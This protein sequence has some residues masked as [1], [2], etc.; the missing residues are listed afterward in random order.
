M[1][2][3]IIQQPD[4]K[5]AMFSSFSDTF[6]YIDGSEDQILEAIGEEAKRDAIERSREIIEQLKAGKKP[7]YQFT[8]SWKEAVGMHQEHRE[9]VRDKEFARAVQ[10]TIE[11]LKKGK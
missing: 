1:G 8:K 5:F 11:R 7:Y 2:R 9:N 4:G 3:Q 6:I 10:E